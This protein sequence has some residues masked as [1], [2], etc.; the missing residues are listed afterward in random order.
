MEYVPGEQWYVARI[1]S[2]AEKLVLLGLQRKQ[3]E[4]LNPTYQVLSKRRDRK[5]ILLRPIFVGYLFLHVELNPERHLEILKT[6]GLIDLLQT[7]HGPTP[8]PPEQ[9]ENVRLLEH[10]VGEL[11]HTPAFEV[12]EEVVVIEGPLTGLRG[13]VDEADRRFLSIQV[14]SI[15]GAIK[16]QVDPA[17]VKPVKR[18]IY[19]T[20]AE[21]S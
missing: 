16:I 19:E 6:Q 2:N 18:T 11:F 21:R 14:D 8:V 1:R 15:P 4:V 17:H 9:I 5:K 7:S 10:H 13:I 12:G 20:V 3:F